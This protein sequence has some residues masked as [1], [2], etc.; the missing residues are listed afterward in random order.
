MQATVDCVR[1]V[2]AGRGEQLERSLPVGEISS[3]VGSSGEV[4][5]E[6]NVVRGLVRSILSD[7]KL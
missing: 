3:I 2:E 7:I 5:W 6:R 4:F 1:S